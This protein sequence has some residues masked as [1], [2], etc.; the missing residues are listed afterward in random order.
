MIEKK[1]IEVKR[2]VTIDYNYICD[3]CGK[4]EVVNDEAPEEWFELKTGHHGWGFDSC[5]SIGYANLCSLK[6][7]F[8][9]I[10]KD[11]W[12]GEKTR[13][14]ELELNDKTIE[15]VIKALKGV[16]LDD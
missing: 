9:C 12:K 2:K 13:Y 14:M 15:I 6:C 5:D 4:E 7:L 10:S 3:I 1:E 16:D 11:E 8:K